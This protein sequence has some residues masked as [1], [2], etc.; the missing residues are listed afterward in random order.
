M[1]FRYQVY[2]AHGSENETGI[3]E[4]FGI[5]CYVKRNGSWLFVCEVDD[6]S[7]EKSLVTALAEN[8]NAVQLAPEHLW[9]VA[10]DVQP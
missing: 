7:P 10:C 6:I 3:S 9:D 2:K 8:C 1:R 4:T 5:R